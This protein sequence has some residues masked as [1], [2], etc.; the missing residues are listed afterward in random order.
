MRKLLLHVFLGITAFLVSACQPEN[1]TLVFVVRHAEKVITEE[2]DDPALT[3][4]GQLRAEKLFS[5]LQLDTVHALYSTD[6]KRTKATL[7]P[8]A[9]Q[10]GLK[11]GLY[12][13]HA[14]EGLAEKIRAENSGQ[15]VVVSGHS[16]TVLPIIEA[17]GATPPLDSIGENDYGYI[18]RVSLENTPAVKVLQYRGIE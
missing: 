12:E 7:Q 6:F 9:E 16:N 14:Y 18:F 17:L 11:V 3:E 4:K 2:T 1:E 10:F 15:N 8:L 13:A 5:S